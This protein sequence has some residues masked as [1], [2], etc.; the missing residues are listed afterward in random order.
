MLLEDEVGDRSQLHTATDTVKNYS[1]WEVRDTTQL[2]F[3]VG[4]D[5]R[6]QTTMVS[7]GIRGGN[8]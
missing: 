4:R 1:L 5:G 8:D 2:T 6:Q 3:E 7:G